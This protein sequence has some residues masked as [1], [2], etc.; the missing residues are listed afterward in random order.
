LDD[1]T[2]GDLVQPKIIKQFTVLLLIHY[3]NPRPVLTFDDVSFEKRPQSSL[4][5]AGFSVPVGRTSE[6]SRFPI[7]RGAADSDGEL[8]PDYALFFLA[9]TLNSS[10]EFGKACRCQRAQLLLALTISGYLPCPTDMIVFF[11]D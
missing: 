10:L 11:L 3:V 6:L 1:R 2:I 8:F 9:I 7:V 5:W 4:R